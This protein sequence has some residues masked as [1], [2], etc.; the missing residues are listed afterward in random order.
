MKIKHIRNQVWVNWIGADAITLWPFIFY[1]PTGYSDEIVFHELVHCW[2]VR[3]HGFFGFYFG[4]L[5]EYLIARLKGKDHFSAYWGLSYET[6]AR[7][8]TDK[9][10]YWNEFQETKAWA[11]MAFLADD[12]DYTKEKNLNTFTKLNDFLKAQAG[13]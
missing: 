2:Q 10:Y 12:K 13:W 11:I 7:V 4:Y 5:K 6:E 9:V 8:L 3:V 1:S